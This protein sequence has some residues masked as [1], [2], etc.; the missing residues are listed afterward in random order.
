M[1]MGHMDYTWLTQ[2][3]IT[4]GFNTL[5]V[6]CT[7]LLNFHTEE[8]ELKKN[9]LQFW[10]TA[11]YP[12]SPTRHEI[13]GLELAGCSFC[14]YGNHRLLGGGEGCKHREIPW[15]EHGGFS[16][17]ESG[18]WTSWPQ[19]S[20]TFGCRQSLPIVWFRTICCYFTTRIYL[21]FNLLYLGRKTECH[22]RNLHVIRRL[23]AKQWDGAECVIMQNNHGDN[24]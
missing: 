14:F 13:C 8:P 3:H 24:W 1:I 9:I 11:N 23:S 22:H 4:F 6:F 7:L 19:L 12:V 10:E 16:Q 5:S 17:T 2:H 21:S 15:V 20:A 18:C